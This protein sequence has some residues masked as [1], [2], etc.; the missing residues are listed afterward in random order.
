MNQ[1]RQKTSWFQRLFGR[2]SFLLIN[3][4]ILFFLVFSFGRE[5]A[6][7]WEIQKEIGDLEARA[8]TLK[9]QHMEIEQLVSLTQTEAFLEKEARLKLGMNKPG[10]QI[11]VISG[12]A[13]KA[14]VSLN[15]E[16]VNGQ[17]SDEDLINSSP[18][19]IANPQKWWYYFFDTQK[20]FFLKSYG[21]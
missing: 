8:E 2:R 14:A 13:D 21:K 17:L 3:L 19:A 4:V 1:E 10:E 16:A 11:V 5:F 15:S 18:V 7:N 9:A 6:R 20:Y 12:T